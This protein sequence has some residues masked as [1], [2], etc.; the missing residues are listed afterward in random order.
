MA[1]H[2]VIVGAD[3][4]GVGK[5]T[6]SRAVIDYLDAQGIANR[7]F[8]TQN[9]AID[10]TG[11]VVGVLKRFY[12]E[13]TEIVDLADLSDQMRVFDAL[14]AE[15]VT[16]IDIKAS[17]LSP[18]LD[19][20]ANIG[21]LDQARFDIDVLH[22]LGNN[23]ASLSEVVPVARRLAGGARHI[24][25]GNRISGTKFDF[26]PDAIEIPMLI[27]GA[28]EAVDKSNKPF[29]QFAKTDK[30]AVLRGMTRTWLD[31]VFAQFAAKKIP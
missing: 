11:K 12:P 15:T 6:V 13:R 9:D 27:T 3:K 29:S 4:G 7:A 26:P 16:V 23:Q 18:S 5:T 10:D 17:M 1:P 25:V 24:L 21:F 14:T 28:A 31:Q 8:D 30:S 2:L 19:L 22:V 20:L